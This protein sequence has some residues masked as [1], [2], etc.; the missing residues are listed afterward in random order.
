MVH[1]DGRWAMDAGSHL[2]CP[3]FFSNRNVAKNAPRA[4][5]IPNK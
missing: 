4:Q 5:S 1:F 3:L 2:R